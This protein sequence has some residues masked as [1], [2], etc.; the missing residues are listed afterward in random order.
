MSVYLAGATHTKFGK[1]PYSIVGLLLE[2]ANE[3]IENTGI[4]DFDEI[5]VGTQ[6]PEEFTGEANIAS[7]ITDQLALTPT[8]A[9]RI[10]TAS[11]S[12]AAVL[13]IA[14]NA[15]AA[16][17]AKR[18]LVLS[19]EKMTNLPTNRATKILA[20]VIDRSERAAGV[21]M[22][23]LAALITKFYMH[24]YHMHRDDLSLVALKNH[25]N[26]L[27]NPRAHLHKSIT[28]ADVNKSKI[29]AEPLRLYDCCP[30]SDGAAAV[31][32]TSSRT[33]VKIIGLGSATDHVPLRNREGLTS[34]SATVNA[35]ERAYKMAGLSP[36]DITFAEI[37]DA[38]TPFEI[39]GS[40]DLGLFEK[41]EGWKALKNG[42]TQIDGGLPINPSGGLKSRGHP[43]G[44]SGMA[45]VVELYWQM[46]GNAGKRQV[47]NPKI[48]LAQS[49]G[50]LAT[51]NFVTILE[52]QN[53]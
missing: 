16:G 49:I 11:S 46:T 4:T 47:L 48:G 35:G 44:A 31:I 8:P 40:E 34:F 20:E 36:K 23:S 2:A 21:S 52:A 29:I 53:A 19:A 17:R 50:G 33:K 9:F 24:K 42:V 22:A 15:V 38:F 37:H 26:G 41:G 10:N 27:L 5:Y 43:V 39:I 7:Q 3:I 13:H 30:L 12:G 51:N 1:R 32:L 28:L 14:Y 25:S 6:N 18:V 45:Q